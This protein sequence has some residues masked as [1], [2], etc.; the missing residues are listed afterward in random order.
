MSYEWFLITSCVAY[1]KH[2]PPNHLIREMT[3]RLGAHGLH[4]WEPSLIFDPAWTMNATEY[5]T[6]DYKHCH[7]GSGVPSRGTL[8]PQVLAVNHPP[9][10]AKWEVSGAPEHCLG[11]CSTLNQWSLFIRDYFWTLFCP[12]FAVCVNIY[13]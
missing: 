9:W 4:A 13:S 12:I 3:L 10:L 8:Y 7:G 2:L 11:A 5:V 1:L 6:H